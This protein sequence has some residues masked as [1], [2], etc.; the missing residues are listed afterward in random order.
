MLDFH[1]LPHYQPV[2]LNPN[3][4]AVVSGDNWYGNKGELT[5]AKKAKK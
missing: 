3:T 2:I 1:G 5:V 4:G